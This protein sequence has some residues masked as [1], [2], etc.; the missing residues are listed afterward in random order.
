[1]RFICQSVEPSSAAGARR[2]RP[3]AVLS[4]KA[5]ERFTFNV[6]MTLR[7]ALWP[8]VQSWWIKVP[9]KSFWKPKPSCLDWIAFSSSSSS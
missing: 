2:W 9:C 5:A 4:L 8:T 1:M 3:T 7:V 6:W